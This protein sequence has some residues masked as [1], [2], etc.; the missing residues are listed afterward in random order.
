MSP[1]DETVPGGAARSFVLRR[2]QVLRLT[3]AAAGANASTLLF[4]ADRPLERLC[5][6][7]TCKA[8]MQVR[9][10]PP[11]HEGLQSMIDRD[12]GSPRDQR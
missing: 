11:R 4:A 12:R 5:V 9:V 6:P 3:A 7:D 1:L 10:R 8:Q 2:T